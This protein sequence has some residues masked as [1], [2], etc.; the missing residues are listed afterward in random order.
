[1]AKSVPA[2]AICISLEALLLNG[3]RMQNHACLIDSIDDSL[4]FAAGWATTVSFSDNRHQSPRSHHCPHRT[5]LC[6][7]Q[8]LQPHNLTVSVTLMPRDLNA[9]RTH[10]RTP[11]VGALGLSRLRPLPFVRTQ[12]MGGLH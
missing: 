12:G 7:L 5:A 9:S 6:S 11:D 10:S 4:G 1:M 2:T 3:T 8:R